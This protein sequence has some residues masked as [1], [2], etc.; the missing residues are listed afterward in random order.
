M[1]KR[2]RNT[3]AAAQAMT[4]LAN[5][6]NLRD[7]EKNSFFGITAKNFYPLKNRALEEDSKVFHELHHR[8]YSCSSTSES[9][10]SCSKLPPDLNEAVFLDKMY[11]DIVP[12]KTSSA[13]HRHQAKK[14]EKNASKQDSELKMPSTP[15]TPKRKGQSQ[16]KKKGYPQDSIEGRTN[17]KMHGMHLE[18]YTDKLSRDSG[19]DQQS[20]W[21]TRT[22]RPRRRKTKGDTL[23][24]LPLRNRVRGLTPVDTRTDQTSCKTKKS[25][26]KVVAEAITIDLC[27]SESEESVCSSGREEDEMMDIYPPSLRTTRID[28]ATFAASEGEE[29]FDSSDS[30]EPLTMTSVRTKRPSAP[31]KSLAASAHEYELQEK[32]DVTRRRTW[33]PGQNYSTGGPAKVPR[34]STLDPDRRN[35]DGDSTGLMDI[36]DED[37][38]RGRTGDRFGSTLY[39]TDGVAKRRYG[40]TGASMAAAAQAVCASETCAYATVATSSNNMKAAAE[41]AAREVEM[42]ALEAIENGML[43]QRSTR[44]TNFTRGTHSTSDVDMELIEGRSESLDD[45]ISKKVP[46]VDETNEL[47]WPSNEHDYLA[48]AA[49]TLTLAQIDA[50]VIQSRKETALLKS[51]RSRLAACDGAH[52]EIDA[53]QQGFNAPM[54]GM[55]QVAQFNPP[56]SFKQ[57]GGGGLSCPVTNGDKAMQ[58]N[59]VS[60]LMMENNRLNS[61]M[62]G[63]S[64]VGQ[65]EID[66][67]GQRRYELNN[68][69]SLMEHSAARFSDRAGGMDQNRI[70]S[71]FSHRKSL[72]SISEVARHAEMDP[73]RRWT[74]RGL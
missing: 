12:K 43:R 62:T 37:D 5:A 28:N 34:I 11:D 52:S 15:K 47:R 46:Y 56:E 18:R 44:K 60:S 41:R 50:A 17:E 35:S 27:T 33:G 25:S 10:C 4:E 59:N 6:N 24:R 42:E 49:E 2:D 32:D 71:H 53:S 63:M 38:M 40:A 73:I 31:V 19:A 1:G 72:G 29:S 51:L 20:G 23:R 70:Q 14:P 58:L 74:G 21:Q 66:T 16:S 61:L 48:P 3:T 65:L 9:S 8:N 26:I 7:I 13:S 69:A 64:D 54:V 30:N 36:E 57:S 55:A 67:Y 22:N 68:G 39:D 45:P